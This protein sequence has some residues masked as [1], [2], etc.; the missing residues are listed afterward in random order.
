MCVF[1]VVN[2]RTLLQVST[3]LIPQNITKESVTVEIV[4]MIEEGS[5]LDARDRLFPMKPSITH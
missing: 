1:P 5:R 4:C 2:I 3:Q